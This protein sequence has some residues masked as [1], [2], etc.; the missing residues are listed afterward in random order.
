MEK[1]HDQKSRSYKWQALL[2]ISALFYMLE[3]AVGGDSTVAG[4]LFGIVGLIFLIAGLVVMWTK[5]S[6]SNAKQ[7]TVKKRNSV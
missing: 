6:K 5:Q 1:T 4:D 2:G 3:I 7:K